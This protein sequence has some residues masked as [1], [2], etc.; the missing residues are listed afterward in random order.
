MKASKMLRRLGSSMASLRLQLFA[1]YLLLD[2]L[3]KSRNSEL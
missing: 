3:S 2:G 1:D